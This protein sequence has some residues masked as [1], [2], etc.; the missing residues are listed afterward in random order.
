ME[1]HSEKPVIHCTYMK[2]VKMSGTF[3][4]ETSTSNKTLAFHFVSAY[5]RLGN[6]ETL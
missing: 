4:W 1:P 3:V 2:E 5:D 6:V